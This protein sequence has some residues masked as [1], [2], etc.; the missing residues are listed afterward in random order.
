MRIACTLFVA[1]MLVASAVIAAEPVPME[2]EVRSLDLAAA[3]IDAGKQR[4]SK[5][6]MPVVIGNEEALA[7]S[8]ADEA[9]QAAIA[10]QVDLEKEQAIFFQ[11]AGSGRDWLKAEIVETADG[12]VVEFQYTAGFTRDLR[13][14]AYLFALPREVKWRFVRKDGRSPRG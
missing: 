1:A 4:Q 2:F 9:S 8:F 3:K 11:W 6:D 12:P 5:V 10:K 13:G 7:T 14:H